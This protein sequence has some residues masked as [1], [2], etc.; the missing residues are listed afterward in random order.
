MIGVLGLYEL[1]LGLERYEREHGV[2]LSDPHLDPNRRALLQAHWERAEL[3][4]SEIEN[5]C[6]SFNA[7]ALVSM[8]SALDALVEELAP[9]VRDVVLAKVAQDLMDQLEAQD[10][11]AAPEYDEETRAVVVEAV[12]VVAIDSLPKL[13]RLL[14]SGAERYEARLRGVGL[15]APSDR[16]VPPDLDAALAE[17]G[18]IRDVLVHRAGRV[19]ARALEQAPSLRYNDG[20]FVRATGDDYRTYSAAIRCYGSEIVAR[21]MTRTPYGP[22]DEKRPD[23]TRWRDYHVAGGSKP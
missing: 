4:S 5:G 1:R 6:P 11:D 17:L 12:R 23:L 15:G 8:N 3:A 22:G 18:A 13:D 19:D 16:A 2:S 10:P 20:E 21:L 14:G 7:H 9:A